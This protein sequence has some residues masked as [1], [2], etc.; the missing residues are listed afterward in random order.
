MQQMTSRQYPVVRDCSLSTTYTHFHDNSKVHDLKKSKLNLTHFP[1]TFTE[2][3]NFSMHNI[4]NSSV[5]KTKPYMQ[6][7]TTTCSPVSIPITVLCFLPCL[8]SCPT[9]SMFGRWIAKYQL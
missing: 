2:V 4:Q 7:I 5:Y 3:F 6:A 8:F 9:K 1:A